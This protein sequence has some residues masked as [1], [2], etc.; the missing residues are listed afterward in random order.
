MRIK[1]TRPR[2]NSCRNH[3]LRINSGF[4]HVRPVLVALFCCRFIFIVFF[5]F[6]SVL[7]NNKPSLSMQNIINLCSFSWLLVLIKLIKDMLIEKRKP[8]PQNPPRVA[9]FL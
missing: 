9:Q 6:F 8:P 2:L 3:F 7:L 5:N 4:G 1:N